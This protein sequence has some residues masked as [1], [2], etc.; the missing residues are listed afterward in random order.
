MHAPRFRVLAALAVL[1]AMVMRVEA[2]ATYDMLLKGGHVIDPRNAS[3]PS[4][5]SRSRA[6]RSRRYALASIRGRTDRSST[7]AASTSRRG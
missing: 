4:W 2:Q 6:G 3:T 5:T 7:S 1:L